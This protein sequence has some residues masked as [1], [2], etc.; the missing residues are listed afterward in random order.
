MTFSGFACA[1]LV[2]LARDS[3]AKSRDPFSRSAAT[4]F[5][6]CEMLF[7]RRVIA[8]SRAAIIFPRAGFSCAR[9]RMLWARHAIVQ[10]RSGAVFVRPLSVRPGRVD[11]LDCRADVR[12]RSLDV[13][14]QPAEVRVGSRGVHVWPP[15]SR[16]RAGHAIGRR[17]HSIVPSL[18]LLI[19]RVIFFGQRAESLRRRDLDFRRHVGFFL[20]AAF[21]KLTA[22]CFRHACDLIDQSPASS[23]DLARVTCS[24]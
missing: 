6:Q 11:I 1:M 10:V 19:R 13:R 15:D 24:R 4:I 16:R 22:E 2:R 14:A 20:P 21:N 3:P 5:L 7:L 8:L 12:V 17:D 23:S 18:S 9:P